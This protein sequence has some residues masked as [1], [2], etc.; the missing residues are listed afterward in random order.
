MAIGDEE[1]ISEYWSDDKRLKADIV[2]I[3][4]FAGTW[5][6]FIRFFKDGISVDFWSC[7]KRPLEYFEGWAEE[8]VM[9]LR[10][11]EYND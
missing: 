10:G 3:V 8:Y 1:I 4:N 6:T 7:Q 11:S 5:S 2:R 9:G